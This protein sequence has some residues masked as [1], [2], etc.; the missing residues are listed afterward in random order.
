MSAPDPAG[1][2][3]PADRGEPTRPDRALTPDGVVA[4]Q[5]AALRSERRAGVGAGDGIRV[6]WGFASPGNQR[7]TGPIQRFAS[8]LRSPAYD[9]LLGHRAA[10]A[11]PVLLD[12]DSARQ[13]VLVLTEDD[14]AQG[15]TWVLCR[16][17]DGVHAGCWLTDGVL[18]HPDPSR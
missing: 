14:R 15:Y 11:G 7:A 4:V 12:G 17:W 18:R 3:P 1:P 2:Q 10:Q 13:E 9:G 16:R 5:L 8:M 6:T